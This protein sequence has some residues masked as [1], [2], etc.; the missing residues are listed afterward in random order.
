MLLNYLNR[1]ITKLSIIFLDI[2]N[3]ENDVNIF[4]TILNKVG[5]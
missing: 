2:Q 1:G 5:R 4:K 3:R